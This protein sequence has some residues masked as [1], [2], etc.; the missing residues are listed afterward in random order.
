MNINQ[1]DDNNETPLSNAI[2][3]VEYNDLCKLLIENGAD[4]GTGSNNVLF[5]L[6]NHQSQDFIEYLL[7]KGLNINE[8]DEE[9]IWDGRTPLSHAFFRRR[10]DLAEK[11]IELGADLSCLQEDPEA[12]HQQC[13][14]FL[15][16]NKF[17]TLAKR[18]IQNNLINPNYT[19]DGQTIFPSFTAPQISRGKTLLSILVASGCFEI[20]ALL[21]NEGANVTLPLPHGGNLFHAL[22]NNTSSDFIHLLLDAKLDI[23][24]HNNNQ[25]SPLA[26]AVING[27]LDLAQLLLKMRANPRTLSPHLIMT[28]IKAKS[29]EACK[30]LLDTGCNA[31]NKPFQVDDIYMDALCYAV[32]LEQREIVKL[33]LL[34]GHSIS[35]SIKINQFD[36]VDKSRKLTNDLF[37]NAQHN[38]WDNVII[39]LYDKNVA[40][41]LSN[42]RARFQGGHPYVLALVFYFLQSQHLFNPIMMMILLR[43]KLLFVAV[44][45]LFQVSFIKNKLRI[46]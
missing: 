5:L 41:I 1:I 4:L 11:F 13:I 45:K 23:N 43:Q 10:L 19:F 33:L 28:T 3:N 37:K 8:N 16:T 9:T 21:I 20:S 42:F 36:F 39:S 12:L 29:Y 44:R 14:D 27:N 25:L 34:Y 18:L 46:V 31:P 22:P 40:F 24:Q 15:V 35:P 7:D 6:S 30:F 2:S 17:L 38:N 32:V 26:L